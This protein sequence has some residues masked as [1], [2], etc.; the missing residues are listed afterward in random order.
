MLAEILTFLVE[1]IATVEAAIAMEEE[2]HMVTIPMAAD[3]EAILVIVTV[4][5]NNQEYMQATQL[6]SHQAMLDTIKSTDS[7]IMFKYRQDQCGT[8]AN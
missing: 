3:M 7:I 8:L 4:Q 1:V 6:A 2:A 5:D